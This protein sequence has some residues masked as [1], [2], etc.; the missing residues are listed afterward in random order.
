MSTLSIVMPNYNHG[1]M[2][3]RAIEAVLEQSRLPDELV[4]MDDGSTDNSV[5]IISSYARQ[6]SF[7]RF[8]PQ[9]ENRGCVHVLQD[10][11]SLMQYD[12][13]LPMGSDDF[14]LPGMIEQAMG[15]LES[16]PQA[17][18]CF[19]DFFTFD[20]AKDRLEQTRTGWSDTSVYW[21]GAEYAEGVK[22]DLVPGHVSVI[23]RNA[24][25]AAGGFRPELQWH[26]D[27]F[28]LQVLAFRHGVCYVPEPF[29]VRRR[30][31]DSYSAVGRR[32]WSV[33][34]G[35]LRTILDLLR[36][37]EYADVLPHFAYSC[38]MS[39]F[40]RDLPRLFMTD[41]ALWDATNIM[42]C[43][44]V[45]QHRVREC[46]EHV[47][48]VWDARFEGIELHMADFIMKQLSQD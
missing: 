2:V 32:D 29:G 20:E 7:I 3:A 19:G 38:S 47:G 24:L 27:W 35:I 9:Q 26:C 18:M 28:A 16:H 11:M 21:S 34:E 22:G 44:P 4:I 6:H 46:R 42:L 12:C 15:M 48:K 36:S 5:E 14:I 10:L 43:M 39:F 13:F 40:N 31:A 8:Y 23:R 1:H 30:H 41:P 37:E 25:E 33:Q 17:G 45:L